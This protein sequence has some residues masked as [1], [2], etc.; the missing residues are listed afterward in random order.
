MPKRNPPN[1][2]PYQPVDAALLQGLPTVFGETPPPP[3]PR[4]ASKPTETKGPNLVPFATDPPTGESPGP[5]DRAAAAPRARGAAVTTP[6]VP[7]PEDLTPEPLDHPVKFRV[8]RSE[9]AELR[10]IAADLGDALHTTIDVANLC[11]AFLLILR[12]AEADVR[13]Q[14]RRAG[15]L[16][17]PR[18]DDMAALAEF[19]LR[20][21]QVLADAFRKAPPVR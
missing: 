6:E 12:H 13:Q 16:R 14:A 1:H 7:V 10:R 2:R 9:V 3:A 21:A 11:R 18:N 20:V 19:D 8:T 17:R 4:P 5:R 15:P